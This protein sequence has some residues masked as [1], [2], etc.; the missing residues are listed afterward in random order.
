MQPEA[1]EVRLEQ[2]AVL[3]PNQELKDPCLFSGSL[4][5]EVEVTVYPI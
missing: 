3:S 4:A 1:R 2:D 5:N